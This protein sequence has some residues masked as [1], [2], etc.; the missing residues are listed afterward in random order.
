MKRIK[1]VVFLLGLWMSLPLAAQLQMG[2]PTQKLAKE[3]CR[4]DFKRLVELCKEQH[5]NL[6]SKMGK[7]EFDRFAKQSISTINDSLT[8]G[9]FLWKCEELIA[10]LQCG[11]SFVWW[12]KDFGLF[13]ESLIFPLETWYDGEKLFVKDPRNNGTSISPKDEILAI[14]DVPVSEFMKTLYAHSPSDGNNYAAKR[15]WVNNMFNTLIAMY[16]NFPSTYQVEI[17]GSLGMKNIE[18]ETYSYQK[19]KASPK[20][21]PL[22]LVRIDSL[23]TAILR[24]SSFNYYGDDISYFRSFI[25]SSFQVIKEHRVQNLVVDLRGNQGGESYCG[26]YLIQHLAYKPFPYWATESTPGFQLDLHDTLVP[27]LNRYRGRPVV[28]MDGACMSTTGHVLSLMKENKFALLVGEEAGSTFT[29]ND[30]SLQGF[31]PESRLSYRIP[32]TTF[33][34]AASSFPKDRGI[35]PD[36]SINSSIEAIV[37]G[38][39]MVMQFVL[40]RIQSGKDW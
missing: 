27:H 25:D 1:Q 15:S 12:P 33:Y 10:Q 17:K 9:G 14:N 32:R 38:H 5:P 6:Q 3:V 28:L 19:K 31:L 22:D 23:S 36:I 21:E 7:R 35:I 30:N 37:I 18:L 4:R 40:E 13:P 2:N 20:R 24:V 26:A 34:T 29:C 39:D 16:F 11:H 8:L